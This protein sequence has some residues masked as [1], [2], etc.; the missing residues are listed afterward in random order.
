MSDTDSP[1]ISSGTVTADP[2]AALPVGASLQFRSVP[3]TLDIPTQTAS[4][5]NWH[6]F[7]GILLSLCFTDDVLQRI[8]GSAVF[9]APGVALCATHVIG[10]HLSCLMAGTLVASCYGIAPHGLQIWVVRKIT[11]IPNTDLTILGVE[12]ASALPPENLFLQSV[13][14]TRLPKVGEDLLICGFRADETAFVLNKQNRRVETSGDVWLCKGTIT[15]RYPLGRDRRMIPWPV[16]EVA[17]P[18]WGGMS[19]GPV[20]E[21]HGL[22]VGLLCSSIETAPG[23]GVS[24]VSMLWPAL[25]TRFESSRPSGLIRGSISLL[26]M[27]R[28]LCAI[29]QPNALA[30]TYDELNDAVRTEYR[31]WE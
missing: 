16:L 17:C 21:S 15:D 8:E 27:D 31:W 11:T 9:I 22:L 6:Y 18:A 28:R 12:L 25:T 24:Y 20:Y 2:T 4:V 3:V 14:T 5:K 26:E 30:A 23:K 1:Q 10:P 7:E 13:I 19:G 29:D